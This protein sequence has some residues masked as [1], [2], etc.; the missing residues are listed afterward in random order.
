MMKEIAAGDARFALHARAREHQA[1]QFQRWI[2]DEQHL[3]VVAEEGGRLVI[4]FAIASISTGNGWQIPQR[5][6][7][8]TD[9]YVAPPR[10]RMGVARRLTGRLLDLLYETSIDTVRLAVAVGSQGAHAFWTSMGWE[11][12]EL[13]LQKEVPNEP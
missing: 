3:V 8:V 2:Q 12:L 1:A 4:G 6:G 5:I 11:D 9:L 10:R 7:R 13:V